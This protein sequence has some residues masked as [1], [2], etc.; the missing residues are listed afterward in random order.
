MGRPDTVTNP[1]SSARRYRLHHAGIVFVLLIVGLYY[2]VSLLDDAVLEP[3]ADL[4]GILL[5]LLGQ[6]T[7][8]R[9][10]LIIGPACRF[11]IVGECTAVFPTVLLTSGILAYPASLRPKLLG[12]LLFVPAVILLNQIRL[13]TLW[14]VQLYAG[15]AFDLVHIYV[16]QP[17]MVVAVL[18][19]FIVWL[20]W[21]NPKRLDSATS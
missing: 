6:K 17:L 2:L 14:F 19:F 4:C 9:G 3:T 13:L 16:W 11:E 12:L 10:A 20:E 1:R 15:D 18:V 7:D 8:V 5:S 21:T